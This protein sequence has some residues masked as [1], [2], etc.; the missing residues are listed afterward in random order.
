MNLTREN[1]KKKNCK[2]LHGMGLEMIL[3]T[4]TKKGKSGMG[5]EM[6]LKT[7]TKK[8]KSVRSGI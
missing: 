7:K 3:K 4:E 5:L 8:G 1:K 6:I 2:K